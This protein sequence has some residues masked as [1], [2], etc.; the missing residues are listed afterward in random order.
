MSR[1]DLVDNLNALIQTPRQTSSLPE[2]AARGAV[3]AKQG[4]GLYKGG[5]ET[6]QSTA[7]GSISSP[8]TEQE[9]REYFDPETITSTDGLIAIRIKATRTLYF[10]DANEAEVTMEFLDV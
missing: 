3:A 7:T 10:R 9:G 2:L 4:T 1:S 8:L 6:T 5:T